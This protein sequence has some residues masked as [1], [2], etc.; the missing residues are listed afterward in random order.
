M[1]TKDIG[2]EDVQIKFSGD[3]PVK[4]EGYASVFNGLD[5]YGDTI[6]P[7]AYKETIKNRKRTGNR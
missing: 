3:K 6:L 2:L 5:S 4:F 7:G 1:F